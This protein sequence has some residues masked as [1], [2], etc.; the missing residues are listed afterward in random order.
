MRLT[1]YFS[2]GQYPILHRDYQELTSFLEGIRDEYPQITRL[3]S[4][5]Q[6]VQGRELWVCSAIR[7][8]LIANVQVMELGDNPG[9]DEPGEPEFKYIANIH[10]DETLGR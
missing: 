4:I 7:P 10:G 9:V 6:S 5:G 1:A 2:V 3:F 8:N